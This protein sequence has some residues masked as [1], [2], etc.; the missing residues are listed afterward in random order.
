M[1][2]RNGGT[3]L[4]KIIPGA[5]T[6]KPS[7]V[8]SPPAARS[9]KKSEAS[10]APSSERGA[11]RRPGCAIL[12]QRQRTVVHGIFGTLVQNS[13]MRSGG[14]APAILPRSA[15]TSLPRQ[16]ASSEVTLVVLGVTAIKA[17]SSEKTGANA[18]SELSN[19]SR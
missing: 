19:S 4:C 11:H 16:R 12:S 13:H 18:G 3:R 5:S 15:S 7:A 8:H 14:A 2:V 10:V 9:Q 6:T 17:F 1:S